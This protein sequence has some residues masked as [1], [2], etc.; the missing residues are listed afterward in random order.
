MPLSNQSSLYTEIDFCSRIKL[1][2]LVLANFSLFIWNQV[3]EC[4]VIVR[5]RG[6]RL[7][8]KKPCSK[9]ALYY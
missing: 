9:V 7:K 8:I 5:L 3:I 6:R 2:L 4:F 1:D